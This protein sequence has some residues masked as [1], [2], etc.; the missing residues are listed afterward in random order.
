MSADGV[1]IAPERVAYQG[2]KP[3]EHQQPLAGIENP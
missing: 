1:V 3:E 2:L